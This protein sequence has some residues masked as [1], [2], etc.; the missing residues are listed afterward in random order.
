MRGGGVRFLIDGVNDRGRAGIGEDE[1]G[2]GVSCCCMHSPYGEIIHTRRYM[3][4]HEMGMRWD[5]GP[6][7]IQIQHVT[8]IGD[9]HE[10]REWETAASTFSSGGPISIPTSL[11]ST[12][13]ASERILN[14]AKQTLHLAHLQSWWVRTILLGVVLT[15][16]FDVAEQDQCL[17]RA[18][19]T[20]P[21]WHRGPLDRFN[22]GWMPVAA[23]ATLKRRGAECKRNVCTSR[24][25]RQF[26]D[27]AS[28]SPG[29]SLI[30][31]NSANL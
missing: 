22:T 29:R 8:Y 17:R 3:N 9:V 6:D 14:R 30:Y 10:I 13:I 25:A 4:A 18:K 2:V 28:R 15:G 7:T 23:R 20:G 11:R 24:L 5:A 16:I 12:V 21:P 31:L 26:K 1:A 27:R 19:D